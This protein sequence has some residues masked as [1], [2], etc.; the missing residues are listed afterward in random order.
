MRI[1]QQNKGELVGLK[2]KAFK[3]EKEIQRLV[4]INLEQISGYK[5]IKSEFIIKSNRIDIGLR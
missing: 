3:L 2:E 1:F 5:F 4:E